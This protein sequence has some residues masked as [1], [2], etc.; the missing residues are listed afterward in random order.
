MPA[1]SEGVI[2]F[3]LRFTQSDLPAECE[4]G[5]LQQAR[6]RLF[7]AGLVGRDP[8]RY[9]GLGFG[10]LSERVGE[11]MRF[12]VSGSQTG[13]LTRLER[14][15]YAL[16]TE[17][18]PERNFI[19]AMGGCPPSSESLTHALLYQLG[20]EVGGVVH[21]H[22]PGLWTAADRLRLPVTPA[23]APYGSVA[24][25][26]AVRELW[27]SGQLARVAGFVM[28]GH[29]DGVVAFG[30]DVVQATDLLFDWLRRI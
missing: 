11:G 30:A 3:D 27:H 1:A 13:G 15:H 10:N 14:E 4:L 22:S 28:L 7:A 18:D 26:R 29:Q 6:A 12:I 5:R 8:A 9:E 23:S 25:V 21:G 17:A 2:H 16:V 24:M 20:A 19:H